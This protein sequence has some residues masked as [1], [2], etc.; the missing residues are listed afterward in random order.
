MTPSH[1]VVDHAVVAATGTRKR[2]CLL[3]ALFS[4]AVV[5]SAI[6]AFVVVWIPQPSLNPLGVN[7][8]A[9]GYFFGLHLAGGAAAALIAT[10]LAGGSHPRRVALIAN[11]VPGAVGFVPL[12]FFGNWGI[13]GVWIAL[14]AAAGTLSFWVILRRVVQRSER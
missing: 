3:L 9:V 12:A 14:M 2:M 13:V 5:L 6:T 11:V 1:P 10:I 4:V 8:Q 7:G